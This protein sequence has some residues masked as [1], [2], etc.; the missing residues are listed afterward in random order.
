M[1]VIYLPPSTMLRKLLTTATLI[2]SLW[3]GRADAGF[4]LTRKTIDEQIQ[5]FAIDETPGEWRDHLWQSYAQ[6]TI[7]ALL[8]EHAGYGKAFDDM[9]SPSHLA[10]ITR[11]G[12]VAF[13]QIAYTGLYEKKR[14]PTYVFFDVVGIYLADRY[15][16]QTSRIL[17]PLINNFKKK[18]HGEQAWFAA[19]IMGVAYAVTLLNPS[20]RQL[21]DIHAKEEIDETTAY[22]IAYFTYYTYRTSLLLDYAGYPDHKPHHTCESLAWRNAVYIGILKEIL[23]DYWLGSG[24]SFYDTAADVVGVSLGYSMAKLHKTVSNNSP[25]IIIEPT[26][27]TAGVNLVISFM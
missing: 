14:T 15:Y 17:F 3:T 1:I 13:H 9:R 8:F 23:L 25:R 11:L 26:R 27:K 18:T 21:F 24:P 5:R 10:G 19:K 12:E 16:E 7:D 4:G 20:E 22:H 2:L 6:T